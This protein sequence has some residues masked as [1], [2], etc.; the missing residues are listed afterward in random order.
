MRSQPG[1]GGPYPLNN[2][3][4][5]CPNHATGVKLAEGFVATPLQYI[6]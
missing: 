1:G 2:P 5:Y 4:G 6:D 3:G